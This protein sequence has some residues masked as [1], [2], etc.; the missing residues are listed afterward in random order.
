MLS[1]LS[2][3]IFC[4]VHNL[5]LYPTLHTIMINFPT[6]QIN[7]TDTAQYTGRNYFNFDL[8]TYTPHQRKFQ[9]NVVL[10]N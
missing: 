3:H 6:K 8:I 7:S 1:L 10:H 5:Y 4:L 9:I 2:Q